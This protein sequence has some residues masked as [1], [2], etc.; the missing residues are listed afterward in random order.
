MTSHFVLKMDQTLKALGCG[1]QVYYKEVSIEVMDL[2]YV[3]LNI[4]TIFYTS[5]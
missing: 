1:I 5:R 2:C 4:A 3:Y